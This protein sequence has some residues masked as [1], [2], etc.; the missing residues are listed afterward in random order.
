MNI[1]VLE[2]ATNYR[3][4]DPGEVF[5]KGGRY[6][7]KTDIKNMDAAE[8]TFEAVDLKTGESEPISGKE[9]VWKVN[10]ELT[11]KQ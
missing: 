5:E 3:E 9:L 7:I 4:I 11:I 1:T 8:P 2:N 10:A 6:F